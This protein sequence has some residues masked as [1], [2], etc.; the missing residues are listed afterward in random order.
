MPT[1]R[2]GAARLAVLTATAVVAAL[3]TAT[4]APG[5]TRA[6]GL[7]VWNLPALERE[8][9]AGVA[10]SRRLDEELGCTFRRQGVK[11]VL[12]AD[13]V[14]GR[15]TLAEVAAAFTDLDRSQPWF[16]DALRVDHPGESDREL[17]A[18][19]VLGYAQ[20]RVTDPA[21]RAEV[22]RRLEGELRSFL[23]QPADPAAP[24]RVD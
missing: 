9:K 7:D 12:V 14:A 1:L 15:A 23:A 21:S 18:R 11:E 19:C 17:V 6:A 13:L 20:S 4:A 5:W 16:P 3:L 10:E 2:P 24:N 8:M 22:R